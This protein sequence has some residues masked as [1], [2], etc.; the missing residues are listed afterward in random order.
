[1]HHRSSKLAQTLHV[2]ADPD[3]DRNGVKDSPLSC[4]RAS[5]SQLP[6]IG[7]HDIN[8]TV[9]FV[10]GVL[11][12]ESFCCTPYRRIHVK[13]VISPAPSIP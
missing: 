8:I 6:G 10:W 11:M 12:K 9:T 13:G 4:V 7:K 1:M 5:F 2:T 3:M